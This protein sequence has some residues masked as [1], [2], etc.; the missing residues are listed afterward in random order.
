MSRWVFFRPGYLELEV[1]G[2]QAAEPMFGQGL[3]VEFPTGQFSFSGGLGKVPE[4]DADLAGGFDD[5]PL[6]VSEDEIDG[7]AVIA[8]IVIVII[9]AGKSAKGDCFYLYEIIEAVLAKAAQALQLLREPLDFILLGGNL[10]LKIGDLCGAILTVGCG[11]RWRGWGGKLTPT[12]RKGGD[13]AQR[14]CGRMEHERTLVLVGS[15][16]GLFGLGNLFQNLIGEAVGDGLLGIHPKVAVAIFF[17]GVEVFAGMLGDDVIKASA[18]ADHLFGFDLQVARR[19]GDPPAN[20]RLVE[21]HAATGQERA[22]A[23]GAAHE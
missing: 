1:V 13:E 12:H 23:L 10:P 7:D 2:A 8:A 20:Q 15:G 11:S 17:H 14:G 9:A 6:P 19:S 3:E 5:I 16:F 18:D 21:Q 4:F 22:F